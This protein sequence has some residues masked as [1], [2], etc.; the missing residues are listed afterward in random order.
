[1]NAKPHLNGNRPADFQDAGQNLYTIA[2]DAEMA[3]R[4]AVS[5]I[6]NGRNY[7]HYTTQT[8]ANVAREQ[9]LLKI[10]AIYAALSDLQDIALELAD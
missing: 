3:I 8:G 4:S 9:D 6:F 10:K 7:Q 1:M 2:T 5:D